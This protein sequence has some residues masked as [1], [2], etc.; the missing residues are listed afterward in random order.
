MSRK[1]IANENSWDK[2]TARG[3]F[4][5]D[6]R[7]VLVGSGKRSYLW[8]NQGGQ[9]RVTLSGPATLRRLAKAILAEV[10]DDA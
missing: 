9:V 5:R 3:D 8:I 4:H 6:D 10:G 7:I 1:I 2:I